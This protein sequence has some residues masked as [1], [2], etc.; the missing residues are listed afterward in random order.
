MMQKVSIIVLTRNCRDT[1]SSLLNSLQTLDYP[2]YEIIVVDSSDDGTDKIVKGHENIK[3]VRAPAL[4]INFARNLG[5]REAA[6]DIVCFIDG[7]YIAPPDWISNILSEF[8]KDQRIGLVGGSVYTLPTNLLGKYLNETL[9]SPNPRYE[10]RGII[11]KEQLSRQPYGDVR[12]PIGGNMAFRRKVFEDMGYFDEEWKIG[13][14]DEFEFIG[15][16]L[17]HGYRVV[18][19]PK[20]FVYRHTPASLR[21]LIE[22]FYRYGKGA[23]IFEK[24]HNVQ[25]KKARGLTVKFFS[26]LLHSLKVSKKEP[27][28]VLYLILDI[29]LSIA[30]VFGILSESLPLRPR[31]RKQ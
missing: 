13:G 28:G 21:E 31:S 6:G 11:T 20:P 3:L 8:K 26:T 23:K 12:L 14:W 19:S 18:V 22:S 5:L 4:G 29:L 27:G 10:R 1:I 17:E 30:Y 9:I 24:K 2:H 7:D 15:R 16:L 25:N